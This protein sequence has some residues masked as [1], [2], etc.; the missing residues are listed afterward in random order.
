MPRQ[1]HTETKNMLRLKHADKKHAKIKAYK[2]K[3][4][5]RDKSIQRQANR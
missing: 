2:D 5:C 3:Q 4:T 1:N